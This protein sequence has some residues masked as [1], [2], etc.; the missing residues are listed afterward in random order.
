[1]C[2]P[3]PWRWRRRCAPLPSR[4][5]TNGQLAAVADGRLVT[6]NADGSGLRALPV[7]GRG[8]DHRA[9]VLARAATGSRSSRRGSSRCSTSPRGRDRAAHATASVTRNP[10]WSADGTTIGF[11]RGAAPVPRRRRRA[12]PP[13]PVS[14]AARR[15]TTDIAWAPD[16]QE[17]TPVVAGPA[18]C[19]PG[20]DLPPAGHRASRRGRPTSTRVAFARAGG[21]STIAPGGAGRAGPRRRRRARRAGRRTRRAL[22]F[23]AR[24]AVRTLTLATGAATTPLAGVEP[25]RA[26]RLA[27]VR[28]RA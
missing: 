8:A 2:L 7:A 16:L 23:A 6:F 11:R 14:R 3:A 1:M 20:L 24:G 12:A 9:R 21:L 27:A 10:A 18:R 17:F 5:T 4:P 25:R 13:E 28:R 15:L 22:V 26:G 19:W